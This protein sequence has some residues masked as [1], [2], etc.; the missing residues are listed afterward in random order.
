MYIP[1]R[2][3]TSTHY[4][5]SCHRHTNTAYSTSR[6]YYTQSLTG[7][8]NAHSTL[9]YSYTDDHKGQLIADVTS[10]SDHINTK[11]NHTNQS[12]KHHT[13]T[14]ILNRYNLGVQHTQLQ[15]KLTGHNSRKTQS[16]L[17]TQTSIPTNI[18]TA[19]IIFY[20]HHTDGRQA[21][22]TKGQ[23]AQQL[24]VLTRPHNMHNHP[25]KTT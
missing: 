25:K 24:H 21:Q 17:F 8:E 12:A 16:P 1:P 9:W 23:D 11:H 14:H 15:E 6:T 20:R 19:N 4:K 13:T 10:N 22:H 3:S 5:N 2:D 7:D 18:H